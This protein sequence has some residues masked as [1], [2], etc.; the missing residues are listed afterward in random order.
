MDGKVKIDMDTLVSLNGSLGLEAKILGQTIGSTTFAKGTYVLYPTS[1]KSG[2]AY[3]L[4]PADG[5]DPAALTLDLG[6]MDLSTPLA[7][8]T[9]AT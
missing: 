9:A 2:A 5:S 3:A 1:T 4:M 8:R 6:S 7:R